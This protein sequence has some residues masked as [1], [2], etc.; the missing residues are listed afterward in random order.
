MRPNIRRSESHAGRLSLVQTA[1]P[2]NFCRTKSQ[3]C[4]ML[5][6]LRGAYSPL[7]GDVSAFNLC[8]VGYK[9]DPGTRR[10]RA[11]GL[12]PPDSGV[13]WTLGS[14]NSTL[15]LLPSCVYDIHHCNCCQRYFQRWQGAHSPA[16]WFMT[17]TGFFPFPFIVVLCIYLKK[18]HSIIIIIIYP[19][20]HEIGKYTSSPACLPVHSP[21]LLVWMGTTSV[22]IAR[23]RWRSWG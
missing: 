10:S 21:A 13:C 17:R 15:L 9:R 1:D 18:T 7:R 14:R 12:C 5:N 16:D 23:D 20:A 11:A 6:K 8:K 3:L 19:A 22:W 2:K 4:E